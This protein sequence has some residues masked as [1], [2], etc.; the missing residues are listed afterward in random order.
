M[1]PPSY[2]QPEFGEPDPGPQPSALP[3]YATPRPW[4]GAGDE[5]LFFVSLVD[6]S[7]SPQEVEAELRALV[8][9]MVAGQH[10]LVAV[11]AA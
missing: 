9:G 4:I 3:G 10:Q 6:T 2:D 11:G 8:R 7:A 1:R 5:R